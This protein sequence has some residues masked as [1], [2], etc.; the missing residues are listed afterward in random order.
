MKKLKQI[1]VAIL[2]LTSIVSCDKEDNISQIDIK[3]ETISAKWD[4]DGTS[5]F[6]SFEFNKNGNYIIVKKGGSVTGKL[7]IDGDEVVLFGTYEILD[8]ETILLSNFGT[9]KITDI[10]QGTMDYTV[11]LEDSE[12]SVYTISVTKAD[13]LT[14]SVKTELLCKTWKLVETNGYEH[15]DAEGIEVLLFSKA[16]TYLTSLLMPQSDPDTE[17]AKWKWQ[18]GTETK[19]FFSWKETPEWNLDNEDEGEFEI[20]ELSENRLVISEVYDN[21]EYVYVL[22]PYTVVKTTK[23]ISV[24][25]TSKTVVK[26]GFLVR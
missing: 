21:E 16:G 19:A 18:D 11:T 10:S 9:I 13:E 26:R 12:K 14:S 1:L 15:D 8:S 23:I 6:K 22:E 3:Q 25:N 17:I 4:V 2:A 5:E 7:A 20:V 24:K